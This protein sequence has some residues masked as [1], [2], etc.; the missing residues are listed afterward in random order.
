MIEIIPNWHPIFVHFTVALLSLSV[1]LFV[2]TRFMDGPLKEQWLLVARWCLWFGVG[3][4]VLTGATGIYAYNTVA[5]DN[6]SHIAMTEHRNW[7]LVTIL[8]FFALAGWSIIIVKNRK[9]F[10]WA[11]VVFS[12]F[13]GLLLA[14]TAWHG[15]EVVYRYGLGVKSLPKATGDGH[16]HD[17]GDGGHDHSSPQSNEGDDHHAGGHD[18]LMGDMNTEEPHA[19]EKSN[20][21]KVHVHDDGHSHEH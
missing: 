1:G 10:G 13:T 2:I 4:T 5:H 17:H 21:K 9:A 7:A 15:G 6:P 14:S 3:F 12:I 20:D 18:D 16:N 19:M 11:F 8:G